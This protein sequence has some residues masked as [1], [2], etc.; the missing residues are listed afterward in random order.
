[1]SSGAPR[2]SAGS[3]ATATSSTAPAQS[4]PRSSCTRALPTGRTATAPGRSSRTTPVSSL[5]HCAH[6]DSGLH[7]VGR[8]TPGQAH[9]LSSLGCWGAWGSPST[10]KPGCGTTT[11]SVGGRCPIVD[12]WWQTE[13]GM[14]MVTTAT[15][16]DEMKPGYSGHAVPPGVGAEDRGRR[17]GAG[18]LRRAATSPSRN[19]GRR[20]C[21]PF[22]ATRTAT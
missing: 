7:E 21:G 6:R 10:R 5:L 13:T 12:T 16:I 20:C 17:R 9:D 8:A 22:G 1:M 2:I 14:I 19:P 15:G 4:G 3:P 18:D 11:T